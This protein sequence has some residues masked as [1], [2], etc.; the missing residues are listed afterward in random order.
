MSGYYRGSPRGGAGAG[1]GGSYP[2][3]PRS[4]SSYPGSPLGRPSYPTSP[5]GGGGFSGGG[6]ARRPP[7]FNAQTRNPIF[8]LSPGGPPPLSEDVERI[9]NAILAAASS[10]QPGQGAPTVLEGHAKTAPGDSETQEEGAGDLTVPLPQRPA[11]GI[12]G[13]PTKL[14]V[15]YIE[16]TIPGPQSAQDARIEQPGGSKGKGKGK[17]KGGRGNP[18]RADKIKAAPEASHDLYKY[19]VTIDPPES[20]FKAARIIKLLLEDE[21]L[22]KFKGTIVSDFGTFIVSHRDI[23][24]DDEGA[25]TMLKEFGVRFR[26]ADQ[27]VP[28]E[29]AQKYRVVVKL[30]KVLSVATLRRYLMS[31]VPG[32]RYG[33]KEEMIQALNI[34]LNHYVKT[35][36]P[37]PSVKTVG[38]NRTFLLDNAPEKMDLTAGVKAVHGFFSSVRP[39]TGR[40][41][42][43][44]NVMHACFYQG[45][46]L[47]TLIQAFDPR[48]GSTSPLALGQFLSR[49]KIQ[50]RH[51]DGRVKTIRGVATS[52][53]G[54]DKSTGRPTGSVRVTRDGA[55]PRDVSF[56]K[57][58]KKAQTNDFVTVSEYFR[59][60][61]HPHENATSIAQSGLVTVPARMLQPPALEYFRGEQPSI[62]DG[63]WRMTEGK[64]FVQT[65]RPRITNPRP[66]VKANDKSHPWTHVILCGAN[67]GTVESHCE[68][69]YHQILEQTGLSLAQTTNLGSKQ[70]CP[71]DKKGTKAEYEKLD[72]VFK[73]L[74]AAK[75]D[76]ALFVLADDD[77]TTYNSIKHLGDAIYGVQ[78]VCVLRDKL[79]KLKQDINSH[80]AMKINLKLGGG[81]DHDRGH[82]RDAPGANIERAT[83]TIVAMV[84]SRGAELG[85]RPGEVA[86]Q[87][88]SRDEMVSE[89]R[90]MLTRRLRLW[91]DHNGGRLPENIIVYR[92]G[93]SEGQYRLVLRHEIPDLDRACAD[94]YGGDGVATTPPPRMTVV[95]VGKR[96][97]TRFYPAVEADRDRDNTRSGT[98]VDRGVT[99]AR[100]G[101]GIGIGSIG[102]V[103]HRAGGGGGPGGPSV[104][105]GSARNPADELEALTHSLCYTFGR[106]TKAVSI[107]TLTYYADIL[108]ER[109]RCYLACDAVVNP[110]AAVDQHA[111]PDEAQIARIRNEAEREKAQARLDEAR[112]SVRE[113][114]R[115]AIK[116]HEDVADTM[117]YI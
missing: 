102:G 109:A 35:G 37:D 1:G 75:V 8:S 70:F 66:G 10:A 49:L 97:N 63:S 88:Q 96:H 51:L 92:D 103:L 87:S 82:R 116:V 110:T 9:E 73:Q 117:F 68:T 36:A 93:V 98:V 33:D 32:L 53:D 20:G 57:I 13:R 65:A 28:A 58:D 48:R 22:Q 54:I 4:G 55:G 30:Q 45:V 79:G 27:E 17:G 18:P 77:T 72:A 78:T 25:S 6:G 15:N 24:A 81:Q 85:Q 64:C 107:P 11:Y 19:S 76:F 95:I 56:Q 29:D 38:T 5:Q 115:R 86:V 80:L 60:I 2:G 14:W 90:G 16:I 100:V 34:F 23:L 112:K 31:E 61:R 3:S 39:A 26:H 41:L 104:G 12:Q 40:M 7:V 114:A 113:K 69:L 21:E 89:P 71:L 47:T 91:K 43:N 59:R 94:V 108:C 101:G 52:T 105:G 44:V 99:E 46:P 50:L 62:R 42:I 106:A 74:V 67:P 84:A 111:P 83:P